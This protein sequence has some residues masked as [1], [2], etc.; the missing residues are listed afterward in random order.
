VAEARRHALGAPRSAGRAGLHG[1]R[2]LY[3]EPSRSLWDGAA[4]GASGGF[5]DLEN[6]PPWDVWLCFA[7]ESFLVSW[8]PPA[9]LDRAAH[10]IEVNPEC[11]INWVEDVETP[12]TRQLQDEGLAF[13]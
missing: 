11:C 12:F 8:V 1:G 13:R 7:D 2:L 3:Y 6:A 5:F 9:F 4:C 10:G